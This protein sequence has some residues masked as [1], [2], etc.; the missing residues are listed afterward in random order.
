M[1][2]LLEPKDENLLGHCSTRILW[3]ERAFNRDAVRTLAPSRADLAARRAR[4]V[5]VHA[6]RTGL[7]LRLAELVLVRPGG[8]LDFDGSAF[9]NLRRER[10]INAKVIPIN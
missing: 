5:R 7:A 3:L 6:E 10:W 9:S 8:A 2:N 4:D 1:G